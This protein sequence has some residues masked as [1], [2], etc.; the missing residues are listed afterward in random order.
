[1]YGAGVEHAVKHALRAV[2]QAAGRA[3]ESPS[4]PLEAILPIT[5]LAPAFSVIAT[6]FHS[7]PDGADQSM[8]VLP[9]TIYQK[10]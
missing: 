10:V 3:K 7:N 8:M 6:L 5:E 1:M 9:K 4:Q 2:K